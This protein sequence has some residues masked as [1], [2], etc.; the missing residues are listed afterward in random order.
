MSGR[1]RVAVSI[2]ATALFAAGLAA[3]LGAAAREEQAAPVGLAATLNRGQEVPTPVG[4]RA[5]ATGRFAATLVRQGGGG[6]LAWRLTFGRLSGPA[7][8]AHIHLGKRGRA[9]PVALALCGPCRSG[10]RG[11]ARA[12]AAAV[13][14]LLAG[15]AYVN[16][17]TARNRAGEIRGQIV[18]G[19]VVLP[20]PATTGTTTTTT[21][22]TTTDSTTT[23]PY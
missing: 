4:T 3:G 2:A 21:T 16:V 6:T 1:R 12:S 23:D 13:M 5:G 11:T 20:P 17:H 10:A 19:A 14:A 9:G 7:T 8:A 18:R 22:T 15:R